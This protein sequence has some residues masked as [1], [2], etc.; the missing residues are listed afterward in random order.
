MTPALA[1]VI[2]PALAAALLAGLRPGRLA[3]R[4][5][6]IASVLSLLCVMA[7]LT[8]PDAHVPILRLDCPAA[9][10]LL[11]IAGTGVAS[12]WA[13]LSRPYRTISR[14]VSGQLMRAAALLGCLA[15][16]PLVAWLALAVASAAALWPA[17]PRHWDHVPLTGGALGLVMFGILMSPVGSSAIQL[18][19]AT[20]V[21]GYGLLAALF[22]SL[23]PLLLLFLL[24]LHELSAAADPMLLALGSLGALGCGASVIAAHGA[25]RRLAHLQLGQAAAA[26]A[27]FGIGTQ[28][29]IFAGL[30]QVSL[31]VLSA[32]AVEVAGRPGPQRSLALAAL[33]G[34]PPLGVFPGIALILVA[35]ARSQAWL[36]LPV[37]AGLALLGWS[38]V[39]R[40]P[41]TVRPAHLGADPAWVPLAL[42]L[43]VGWFLPDAASVWLRMAAGAMP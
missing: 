3:A 19:A 24:R 29:G 23:L 40:L 1:A 37:G 22:P 32:I 43:L 11:L 13:G 39:A 14:R 2:L 5:D 41:M 33:G 8:L 42:L 9:L 21:I 34:V 27:A 38:T 4:V 36:L 30:V 28:P 20:Q 6:G 26:V 16:D 12:G 15:A 7:S 25:S 10:F 18:V 35:L 17:L 31:L